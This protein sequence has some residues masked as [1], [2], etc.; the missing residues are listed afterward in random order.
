MRFPTTTETSIVQLLQFLHL[1]L[2]EHCRR[3]AGEQEDQEVC[4]EMV[5][6]IYD[7]EAE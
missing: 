4:Y 6:F 5:S 1:R 2:T 3:G 7:R